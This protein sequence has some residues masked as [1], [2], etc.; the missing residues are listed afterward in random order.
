MGGAIKLVSLIGFF[1]LPMSRR[2]L[3]MTKVLSTGTLD[4]N[5]INQLS[6]LAPTLIVYCLFPC[7]CN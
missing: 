3:E 2:I 1:S 4:L 7:M 6:I 5:S